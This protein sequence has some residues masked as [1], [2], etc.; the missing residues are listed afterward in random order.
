MISGRG[1]RLGAFAVLLL[2]LNLYAGP[3]AAATY[4]LTELWSHTIP[5]AEVTAVA[6]SST[7]DYVA[8]G[9][10]GNVLYLFTRAG[11][12]AWNHSLS[13]FTTD[14][15]N[16]TG[17]ADDTHLYA[18]S[19]STLYLY[20][21]DGSLIGT[22]TNATDTSPIL[23]AKVSVSGNLVAYVTPTYLFTRNLTT[24]VLMGSWQPHAGTS[25]K[26]R[27]IA[28]KADGSTVYGLTSSG[29][30]EAYT[31]A[32]F[33]LY[34]PTLTGNVT[35]FDLTLTAPGIPDSM[36]S[37]YNVNTTLTNATLFQTGY[38]SNQWEAFLGYDGV[39]LSQP[40]PMYFESYDVANHVASIWFKIHDAASGTAKRIYLYQNTSRT[41]KS[42]LSTGWA[43]FP[44]GFDDWKEPTG[45]KPNATAWN[46]TYR[47]G[48]GTKNNVSI[49]NG[50]LELNATTKMDRAYALQF[51][52]TFNGGNYTLF[53]NGTFSVNPPPAPNGYISH[54]IGITNSTNATTVYLSTGLSIQEI[55][56]ASYT[57]TKQ[58]GNV[59]TYNA[60]PT[61]TDTDWYHLYAGLGAGMILTYNTTNTGTMDFWSVGNVYGGTPATHYDVSGASYELAYPPYRLSIFGGVDGASYTAPY[62]LSLKPIWVA[63]KDMFGV[64]ESFT[65]SLGKG[66]PYN[67]GIQLYWPYFNYSASKTGITNAQNMKLDNTEKWFSV[68]ATAA[69]YGQQVDGTTFG[70][71]YTYASASGAPTARTAISGAGSFSVEGRGAGI[72]DV[73]RLDGTRVGTY[74][75]GGTINGV[76]A[77]NNGLWA[78]AGSN[79]GIFY[80]F[81]KQSSSSW[82]LIDTSTPAA[83]VLAVD[84]LGDGSIGAAGRSDG[85]LTLYQVG[86]ATTGGFYQ[87]LHFTKDGSPA[88]GYSVKV[89][90]GGVTGT[91]Y[92]VILAS[93]PTDSN[94][95]LVFSATSGHYY[96]I[97]VDSQV[98]IIQASSSYPTLYLSW[99]S[100]PAYP[101]YGSGFNVTNGTVD[102]F[103]RDPL[104]V[105]ITVEIKNTDTRALAFCQTFT[106]DDL[107]ISW[108]PPAGNH[109]YQVR[110]TADRPTGAT[111]GVF[112]P[113]TGTGTTMEL[114]PVQGPALQIL[115]MIFLMVVAGL[116]G[117]V[118]APVGALGVSVIAVWFNYMNWLTIPWY[119]VQLTVLV[120]F[121]AMLARGADV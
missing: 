113:T 68:S 77:S 47:S 48:S 56:Y 57:A 62:N 5:G 115:L 75:A 86:E 96:R 32:Q 3:A 64:A 10:D 61:G 112:Y 16:G 38:P 100:P 21:I 67:T 25:Y 11:V 18:F 52:K 85:T 6:L 118:H 2:L 44:Y 42:D 116:F 76:A 99:V 102:T 82:Q 88:V 89:E 97:T 90:E 121:M 63:K 109:H 105:P 95:D 20:G 80:A 36:L 120:A 23:A 70:T 114:T 79:D 108:S 51:E 72:F 92:T 9:T 24:G 27:D 59:F 29:A 8:A 83:E 22:F 12:E 94:G 107:A 81:G 65:D 111:G 87:L 91:T 14:P 28:I 39:Q 37:G 74:T 55:G 15:V 46:L 33:S 66:G 31:I 98:S 71:Q 49:I 1:W 50:A 26:W 78:V 30:I 58:Q 93:S 19:N 13:S 104:T 53:I 17:F 110:I 117:Y 54:I 35:Y 4:E 119:W 60:F 7:G 103:Y 101:E 84:L 69:W 41:V 106:T 34:S 73:I 40:I 45:V 43:T